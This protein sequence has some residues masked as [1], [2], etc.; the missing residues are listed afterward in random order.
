[1]G[2]T[3]FPLLR[4]TDPANDQPTIDWRVTV[5]ADHRAVYGQP[6]DPASPRRA[7]FK[8][9][10]SASASTSSIQFSHA[11]SIPRRNRISALCKTIECTGMI[12][13][14]G[15]SQGRSVQLSVP[16]SGAVAGT[17]VTGRA[18]RRDRRPA[19][20]TSSPAGV[21]ASVQPFDAP[22]RPSNSVPD[23]RDPRRS[24]IPPHSDQPGVFVPPLMLAFSSQ[25]GRLRER[26][27]DPR[28]CCVAGRCYSGSASVPSKSVRPSG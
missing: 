23:R 16:T 19:C 27:A 21:T 3:A 1:M 24:T 12:V 20:R 17:L 14:P 25:A 10:V 15:V 11:V 5:P 8:V 9:A 4:S 26:V 28:D 13:T 7:S 6:P 22:L 18:V 2:G